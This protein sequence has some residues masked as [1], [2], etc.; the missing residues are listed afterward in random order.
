LYRFC[1]NFEGHEI[2]QVWAPEGLGEKVTMAHDIVDVVRHRGPKKTKTQNFE[3][4]FFW[5]EFGVD[6]TRFCRSCD[7]CHG[8]IINW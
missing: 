8:K 2:F 4:I 7:I 5:P 3:R 1:K 6:V